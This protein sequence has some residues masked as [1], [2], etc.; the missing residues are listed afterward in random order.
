MTAVIRI[1]DPDQT[2]R[3]LALCWEGFSGTGA[4]FGWL[5]DGYGPGAL[6]LEDAL[7]GEAGECAREG[8]ARDAG[9]LGHLLAREGGLED[10]APLGN[11]TLLG[12]EV[13]EHARHPLGGAVEDEVTHQILQLPGPGSQG[14]GEP[15]GGFREA[16]HDL[17]QV[18]AED[19]VEHAVGEGRGSPILGPA[20][21]RRPQAEHGAVADHAED[22]V[23]RLRATRGAVEFRP[24]LAHEVDGARGLALAVEFGAGPDLHHR[25][26]ERECLEEFLVE[27]LQELELPQALQLRQ[28]LD[29]PTARAWEPRPGWRRVLTVQ[30]RPQLLLAYP[31]VP[32][33]A[34]WR[35]FAIRQTHLRLF[36]HLCEDARDLQRPVRAEVD[37]EPEQL[38]DPVALFG[39]E[40]FEDLPDHPCAGFHQGV[41][42]VFQALK[43]LAPGLRCFQF[44]LGGLPD[45]V[46]L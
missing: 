28:V 8:F 18:V 39:C 29:G 6:Q 13:E 45:L 25:S 33:Y 24:P 36:P 35:R 20:F 37:A 31:R 11:S 26:R 5:E 41:P 2:R 32:L 27:P 40:V 15:E 21:E 1:C 4:Q 46:Q 17:E 10:D 12:G 22:L 43:R 38:V 16:G 34:K 19:G 23:S 30:R 44:A 14:S 42:I 7:P 9:R 3:K